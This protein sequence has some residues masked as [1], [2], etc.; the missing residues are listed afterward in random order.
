MAKTLEE[1]ASTAHARI[2]YRIKFSTTL[3]ASDVLRLIAPG[4]I[5]STSWVYIHSQVCFG[6]ELKHCFCPSAPRPSTGIILDIKY[7]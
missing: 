5:F 3:K 4:I 2:S 1:S 7:Y 6:G